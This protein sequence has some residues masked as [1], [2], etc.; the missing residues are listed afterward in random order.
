MLRAACSV[1]RAACLPALCSACCCAGS[2]PDGTFPCWAALRP[3]LPPPALQTQTSLCW[4]CIPPPPLFPPSRPF[5][6]ASPGAAGAAR[7]CAWRLRRLRAFHA[8]EGDRGRHRAGGDR[9]G[10]QE[11]KSGSWQ[12]ARPSPAV[13]LPAC[14]QAC[15]GENLASLPRRPAHPIRLSPSPPPSSFMQK[16]AAALDGRCLTRRPT[17]LPRPPLQETVSTGKDPRGVAVCFNCG[18]PNQLLTCSGAVAVVVVGA[19]DRPVLGLLPRPAGVWKEET[20]QALA[21]GVDGEPWTG[22]LRMRQPKPALERPA[23]SR[24]TA[25][26]CRSARRLPRRRC[27]SV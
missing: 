12:A 13:A 3:A 14:G 15:T 4:C 9:G 19:E 20:G 8:G 21:A 23:R 2:P 17:A 16:R 18:N 6:Q 26:C 25:G 24:L 27:C 7:A 10:L 5:L 11:T 22:G 1:Q